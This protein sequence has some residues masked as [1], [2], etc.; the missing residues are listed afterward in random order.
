MAKA[1]TT[2]AN[3]EPTEDASESAA[4]DRSDLGTLRDKLVGLLE[5]Q[6]A[7]DAGID[8]ASAITD[9]A[10]G[11]EFTTDDGG[12]FFLTVEPA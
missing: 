8:S 5:S 3:D 2:P 6:Q 9:D 7:Q 4:V 12:E 10:G 11:I 1:T